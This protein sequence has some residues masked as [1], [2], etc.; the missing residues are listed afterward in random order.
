MDECRSQ[1]AIASEVS[2]FSNDVRLMDRSCGKLREKID[3]VDVQ[4]DEFGARSRV[5]KFAAS[6]E[7]CFKSL[8]EPS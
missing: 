1:K 8:S 7:I 3:D 4:S 6:D 5:C 2:T